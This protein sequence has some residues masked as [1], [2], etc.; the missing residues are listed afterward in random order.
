MLRIKIPQ[1]TSY[2]YVE[3]TILNQQGKK[4]MFMGQAIKNGQVEI[5]VEQLTSGKYLL[6]INAGGE[7]IMHRIVKL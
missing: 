5:P 7:T 1:K 4:V 2:N 3:I 6:Q